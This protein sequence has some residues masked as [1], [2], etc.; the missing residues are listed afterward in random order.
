MS[1]PEYPGVSTLEYLGCLVI[2]SV[3]LEVAEVR[4]PAVLRKQT[5]TTTHPMPGECD[6]VRVAIQ[7]ARALA[8]HK[9]G[10]GRREQEQMATPFL[11]F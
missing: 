11:R 6:A 5:N 9:A 4:L 2:L 8:P 3:A 1:T 7:S 10:E